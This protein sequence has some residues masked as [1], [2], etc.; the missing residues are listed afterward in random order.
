[1]KKSK[2]LNSIDYVSIIAD[3][4]TDISCH[5]Q[6]VLL[7]C[8]I[9]VGNPV[10]GFWKF[11][12]PEGHDA[13]AISNCILAE[14]ELLISKNPNKLAAQ[15]YD[16]V[17]LMIGSL[18]SVHKLIKDKYQNYIH[19]Y[20]HQVNLIMSKAASTNQQVYVFRVL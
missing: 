13:L 20:V 1:M 4:T 8:Y 9:V 10:E 17:S 7:L 5:F 12:N 15:S 16:V 19:C 6:L 11:L 2:K 18:H 3:D 14:L